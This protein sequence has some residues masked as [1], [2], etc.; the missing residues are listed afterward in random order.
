MSD[1]ED[2]M[3]DGEYYYSDDAMGSESEGGGDD[4]MSDTSSPKGRRYVLS[5]ETW[6]TQRALTETHLQLIDPNVVAPC[7][8][9]LEDV[10]MYRYS[11]FL[12]F[13]RASLFF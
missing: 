9:A 12:V 2:Y 3:S 13:S 7:S 1:F 8:I 6:M 11:S 4:G 5:L 10:S